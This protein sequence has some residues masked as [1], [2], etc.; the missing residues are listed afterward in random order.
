MNHLIRTLFICVT[1]L[2]I[3]HLGYSQPLAEP[4]VNSI[5][6][7]NTWVYKNITYVVHNDNRWHSPSETLAL[8]K[9]VCRDMSLLVMKIVYDSLGTASRLVLLK[10]KSGIIWH[11]IVRCNGQYF[12]P[13]NGQSGTEMEMYW[14]D[15]YEDAVLY[16]YQAEKMFNM[17]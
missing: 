16:Y 3:T 5:E 11:A 10:P 14:N 8:K 2:A 6:E 9:G 13:T 4:K 15:F 17:N 1:F 7:A 12:D